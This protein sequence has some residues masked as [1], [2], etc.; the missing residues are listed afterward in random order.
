[1]PTSHSSPIKLVLFDVGST[2][3]TPH[4]SVGEV[5][6]EVAVRHGYTCDA[7]QLEAEFRHVFGQLQQENRKLGIDCY[8]TTDEQARRFWKQIVLQTFERAG[9]ESADDTSAEFHQFFDDVYDEFV[10]ADRYRMEPDVVET[11]QWLKAE[12]V[13]VGILSNWDNRLRSILQHMPFFSLIDVLMVSAEVGREKPDPEFF[14]VAFQEANVLPEQTLHIGDSWDDDIEGAEAAG[15]FCAWYRPGDKSITPPEG[16][17]PP[18]N[19]LGIIRT[20]SEVRE[21]LA[22]L[23]HDQL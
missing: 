10:S 17:T 18:K 22:A 16:R 6:A 3:L 15:C 4:P 2:L 23:P 12:G 19:L 13:Q 20:L 14:D 21:L 9:L 7:H 1:M 5:Y 8:G 11:M